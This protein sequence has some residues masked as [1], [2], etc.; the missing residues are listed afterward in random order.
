[1][2][3]VGRAAAERGEE[4]VVDLMEKL[5][6]ALAERSEAKRASPQRKKKAAKSPGKRSSRHAA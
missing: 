1:V 4:T 3:K 5:K 2:V 6:A